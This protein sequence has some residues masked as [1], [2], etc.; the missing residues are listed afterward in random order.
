MGVHSKKDVEELAQQLTARYE[1]LQ[2]VLQGDSKAE[3]LL[4]ELT[5]SKRVIRSEEIHFAVDDLA[6]A[7]KRIKSRLGKD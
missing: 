3:R 4:P 7:L 6:T 2:S 5:A 1:K